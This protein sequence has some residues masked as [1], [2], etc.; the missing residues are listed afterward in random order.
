MA[1]SNQRVKTQNLE[2]LH[3]VQRVAGVVDLQEI[4]LVRLRSELSLDKFTTPLV[5]RFSHKTTCL[6]QRDN[7]LSFLTK[8]D[9]RATRDRKVVLSISAAYRAT[10]SVASE[11]PAIKDEEIGAFAEF[12]VPYNVWPYWREL[13]QSLTVRMGLPPLTLPLLK[14]FNRGVRPVKRRRQEKKNTP[15]SQ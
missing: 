11:S 14:P 9:T 1:E 12:N 10:Y 5:L 15:P 4:E 7:T 3:Q 8:L 13:V 2:I 6:S